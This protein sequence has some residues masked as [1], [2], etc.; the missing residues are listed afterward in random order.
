VR[1]DSPSATGWGHDAR[2]V[3]P[4]LRSTSASFHERKRVTTDC[5]RSLP[6]FAPAPGEGE[7]GKR[8]QDDES[9]MADEHRRRIPSR[10]GNNKSGKDPAR[11]N[12]PI[13]C[14]PNPLL[15]HEGLQ[16]SDGH[17]CLRSA[18]PVPTSSA[19]LNGRDGIS[20][21]YTHMACTSRSTVRRTFHSAS[22]GRY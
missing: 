20:T 2:P 17:V 22:F 19:R 10:C 8:S 16:D 5:R 11:T 4:D 21:E 15:E 1:L 13:V 3:R 7:R 12:D 6:E 18:V 9:P 14:V